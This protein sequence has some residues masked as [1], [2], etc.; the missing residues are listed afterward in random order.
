MTL[1]ELLRRYSAIVERLL[2]LNRKNNN[3]TISLHAFSSISDYTTKTATLSS[4]EENRL[5]PIFNERMRKRRC[6]ADKELELAMFERERQNEIFQTTFTI[7]NPAVPPNPPLSGLKG[8]DSLETA[9]ARLGDNT[10]PRDVLHKIF[11]F[12]SSSVLELV[13]QGCHGN[14]QKTVQQVACNI[15]RISTCIS[16]L[17]VPDFFH[18]N[19]CPIVNALHR[20]SLYKSDVDN[21]QTSVE[22]KSKE[23]GSLKVKLAA[24]REHTVE[25]SPEIREKSTRTVV[26]ANSSKILTP[27]VTRLKFSVASIIGEQ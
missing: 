5:P 24:K 17:P 6:F 25:L 3:Q 26:T 9:H 4:E 13:W 15:P 2:H 16:S 12:H 20:A 11:P 8:T 18:R 7:N 1:C 19:T 22:C 23:H 10:S 27:N 21:G 14:L